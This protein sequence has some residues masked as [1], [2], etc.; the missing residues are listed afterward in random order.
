MT[1]CINGFADADIRSSNS[2]GAGHIV[3]NQTDD[4]R[5]ALVTSR[6]SD[7]V[8]GMLTNDDGAAAGDFLG[9]V[10]AGVA[11]GKAG[12][13]LEPFDYVISL[14]DSEFGKYQAG[15]G[16]VV[17][18]QY[19]PEAA[20]DGTDLP[21]AVAGEDVRVFL[22]AN[23]ARRADAKHSVKFTY[24]VSGGDDGTA[25]TH[26]T[27]VFLPDNAV[28][29]KSLIDVITTFTDGASDT[30]TIALGTASEVTIDAAI[31]ISDGTNPW[32][33]GIR[34]GDHDGAGANAEKT[35]SEQQI[36]VTT[37]TATITAGKLVCFVD[38]Y[39]SE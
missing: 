11:R 7:T 21:D 39:I 28:V 2:G 13:A 23:K 17:V 15:S 33:A 3:Q 1:T 20:A 10:Y 19:I 31:A 14:T 6:H 22:F 37:A 16:A 27:G 35:T 12:E 18:G 36:N 9:F 29:I 30:A 24:D 5:L 34:D 38:Y 4:E 26:A 32:D 8:V 25:G